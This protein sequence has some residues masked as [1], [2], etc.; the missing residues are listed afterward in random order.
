LTLITRHWN[1]FNADALGLLRGK[2]SST[3][4]AVKIGESAIRKSLQ[5]Q[6]GML[7]DDAPILGPYPTII[8]EIG[9]PYDMDGKKSYG[10]TDNGKYKGDYSS[11][12][13]ALD[14]SLNAAD[15]P[16]ALSYAI[17]N[18]CPDNSHTWG[19]N[20]NMED[21]SLWSADD[22]RS[23]ESYSMGSQ[24]SSA[25]KLLKE[26]IRVGISSAT[27]GSSV[28]LNSLPTGSDTIV[29][30]NGTISSYSRWQN[31]YDFL[32]DGA[33]AVK[34]F[35]RPYPTSIIGVPKDIQFDIS[36]AEFKLTVRVRPED[37]PNP[38]GLKASSLEAE[39]Q[40]ALATEIYVPLVHYASEALVDMFA[41]QQ[42]NSFSASVMNGT[43]S[44]ASSYTPRPASLSDVSPG[45]ASHLIV[46]APESTPLALSVRVSDGRWAVEGQTLKWWYGVPPQGASEREY[47]IS[48][49]RAGGPIKTAEEASMD[50]SLLEEL[51][52]CIGDTCT[53]M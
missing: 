8:G 50:R 36:K 15:G 51:S 26:Q 27:A 52:S 21:L 23:N 11:Q 22:L 32:T 17:W 46:F 33:R 13:K 9:I 1:W 38:R 5:E 53:L 2:Y 30:H 20:W 34:A 4:P 18:Y 6:L 31:A 7:K 37:A 44:K 19:D 49:T 41:E 48:I 42:C 45:V 16:N 12:Q 35:C 3:L 24:G 29:E 25:A 47:T 10:W 43:P 28:S 39:P 40:E 14:A